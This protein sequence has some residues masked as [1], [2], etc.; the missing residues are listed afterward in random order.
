VLGALVTALQLPVRIEDRE[1]S[2]RASF[3]VAAGAPD[4][5]VRRADIAMY[6]AKSH[7]AGS[8]RHYR[9]GMDYASAPARD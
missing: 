2:V 7:G 5:L 6:D 8:W 3:G 1:H 4:E 9:A